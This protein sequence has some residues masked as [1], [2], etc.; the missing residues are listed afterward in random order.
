MYT[1]NNKQR[2]TIKS[3]SPFGQYFNYL[4]DIDYEW[5]NSNEYGSIL[6]LSLVEEVGE[7]A[8]A[9]LAEHGRKQSNIAAQNDEAQEQELGDILI[10]ILRLARIKKIDLHARIMYSLTKIKKRKLQPKV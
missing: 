1:N 3:N 5:K 4:E 10:S 6:L 8:R 2:K 9:Y 7:M